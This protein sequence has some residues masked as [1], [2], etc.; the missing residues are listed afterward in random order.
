MLVIFCSVTTVIVEAMKVG[1]YSN[2]YLL[3]ILLDEVN[4]FTADFKVNISMLQC[5]DILLNH[6][7]ETKDSQSSTVD[8]LIK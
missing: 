8:L 3:T 4:Y 7:M 2:I 5:M 1:F 6:L